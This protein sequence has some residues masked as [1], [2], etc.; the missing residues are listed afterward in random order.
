M[1]QVFYPL[2]II[3]GSTFQKFLKQEEAERREEE[4]KEELLLCR[5]RLVLPCLGADG[6]LRA[7]ICNKRLYLSRFSG[8]D[9]LY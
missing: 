4:E 3:G 5:R 6:H 2:Y 8:T 1:A 7:K 9:F